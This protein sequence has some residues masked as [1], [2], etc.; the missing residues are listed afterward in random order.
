[1]SDYATY[2]DPFTAPETTAS[3]DPHIPAA[4][5]EHQIGASRVQDA[6]QILNYNQQLIQFADSKAG[7]LIVINSLFIAA[8]QA[9]GLHSSGGF[10]YMLQAGYILLA[11]VAVLYCLTVI[12]SKP[13]A[14][15]GGRKDLIFFGDIM[16]R[17]N[18]GQYTREFRD[19][20]LATHLDD[21]LKRTHVL[22]SI[23]ARKF[24]S[25]STAQQVTAYAAYI[26]VAA[27]VCQFLK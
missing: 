26:W 11:C 27:N 1:M 7:N 16:T 6:Y 8:A 23:A 15:P 13:E 25:Y 22:A 2:A 14:V 5:L 18:V 19:L 21:V 12:M 17:K 10:L 24:A 9:Q 3:P 4:A 20:T